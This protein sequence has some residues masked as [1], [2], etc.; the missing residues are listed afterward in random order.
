MFG[1][2]KKTENDS[3]K[4]LI[5]FLSKKQ[6]GSGNKVDKKV[7]LPM[8]FYTIFTSNVLIKR[9]FKKNVLISGPS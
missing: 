6:F 2:R 5:A 1:R 9:Y 3:S 8:V 4:I 7:S